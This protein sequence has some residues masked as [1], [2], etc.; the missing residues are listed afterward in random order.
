MV[1]VGEV[2]RGTEK[3]SCHV[4]ELAEGK[5]GHEYAHEKKMDV[6]DGSDAFRD[7]WMKTDQTHGQRFDLNDF[8]TK[9]IPFE[10]VLHKR[11]H[12]P[13][14]DTGG[15]NAYDQEQGK[16]VPGKG[17]RDYLRAEKSS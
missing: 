10:K 13:H 7:G 8:H 5:V 9:N 2:S 16:V 3:D 15:C 11:T 12:I 17:D 6:E 1:V 14:E 4:H